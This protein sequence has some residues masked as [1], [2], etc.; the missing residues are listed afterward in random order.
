MPSGGSATV[1]TS[2]IARVNGKHFLLPI[3]SLPFVFVGLINL[4]SIGV[5]HILLYSEYEREKERERGRE[6]V[7]VCVYV[8]LIILVSIGVVA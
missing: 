8:R 4:A 7:C 3:E 5:I 6:R 2:C 1:A